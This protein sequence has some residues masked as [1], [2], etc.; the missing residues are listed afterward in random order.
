MTSLDGKR[1]ITVEEF[2]DATL[3]V[4]D[5]APERATRVQHPA[6]FP[7]ELPQRLIELPSSLCR[8]SDEVVIAEVLQ[9]CVAGGSSNRMVRGG[10]A[11]GESA[12]G[13]RLVHRPAGDG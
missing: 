2:M 7:V 1:T 11:V 5:I 4:W 3:D 9:D 12:I 10:E 13:E 8:C 6:P